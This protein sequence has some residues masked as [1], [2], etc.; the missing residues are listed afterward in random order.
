MEKFQQAVEVQVSLN[1]GSTNDL[2]NDILG[3]HDAGPVPSGLTKIKVESSRES[4]PPSTLSYA[5]SLTILIVGPHLQRKSMLERK[6]LSEIT[7]Y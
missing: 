6:N 5:F 2:A 3:A 7:R 1:H 4:P